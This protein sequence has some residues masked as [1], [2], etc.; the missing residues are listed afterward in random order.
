MKYQNFKF[1]KT[2]IATF[3]LLNAS[4]TGFAKQESDYTFS[5]FDEETNQI[6]LVDFEYFDDDTN[7]QSLEGLQSFD[8]YDNKGNEPKSPLIHSTKDRLV[9]QDQD[10]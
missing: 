7:L 5:Y 2:F 1:T 8:R 10:L 6:K 3:I 4:S 9:Y